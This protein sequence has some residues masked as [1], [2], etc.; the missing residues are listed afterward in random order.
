MN[1]K[2]P[3]KC[4]QMIWGGCYKRQCSRKRKVTRDGKHYCNQHDP[5][6]VAERDRIANEEWKKERETRAKARTEA[7]KHSALGDIAPD[8]LKLSEMALEWIDAVPD[9]AQLPAM[10][11]FDRDWADEIVAKAK[12]IK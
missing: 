1:A 6:K 2:N 8:L 10:P 9:D 4:A 12:G 11:G 5:V 7:E 3:D